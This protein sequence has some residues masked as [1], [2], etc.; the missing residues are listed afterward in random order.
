MLG[1]IQQCGI[2]L[3]TIISPSATFVIRTFTGF[4]SGLVSMHVQEVDSTSSRVR[5]WITTVFGGSL[6]RP[7]LQCA[8]CM[9]RA[10]I[11]VCHELLLRSVAVAVSASVNGNGH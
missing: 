9:C 7:P 2:V 1:A 8:L 10:G 5:L 3:A 6:L 11:N 4:G